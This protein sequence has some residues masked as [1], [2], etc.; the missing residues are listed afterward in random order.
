ME[1]N[2]LRIKF[3]DIPEGKNIEDYPE[4]TIFILDDYDEA[5]DDAFW[6]E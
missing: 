3:G 5:E 2:P 6:E 1:K 4:D